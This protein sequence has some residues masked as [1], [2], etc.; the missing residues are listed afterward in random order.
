MEAAVW[1]RKYGSCRTVI[2]AEQAL[3]RTGEG[4]VS[5]WPSRVRAHRSRGVCRMRRRDTGTD[6]VAPR[7][8][9]TVLCLGGS[10]NSGEAVC[11]NRIAIRVEKVLEIADRFD[12]DSKAPQP[13]T[14]RQELRALAAEA[15]AS[16]TAKSV[17]PAGYSA[18]AFAADFRSSLSEPVRRTGTRS[19][20]QQPPLRFYEGRLSLKWRP[21]RDSRLCTWRDR[22]RRDVPQC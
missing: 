10:Y 13:V 19:Q 1:R 5:G 9:S 17:R 11:S 8:T 14:L 12:A 18:P 6:A 2:E 7:S 15:R 20:P 3:R 21:Q 22:S 16:L 4:L